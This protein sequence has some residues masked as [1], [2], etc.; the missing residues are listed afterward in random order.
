MK[1][2][3]SFRPNRLRGSGGGKKRSRVMKISKKLEKDIRSV[4]Q[5]VYC[6]SGRSELKYWIKVLRGL[7][8]SDQAQEIIKIA[9]DQVKKIDKRFEEYWSSQEG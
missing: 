4:V 1:F 7:T 9:K 6:D 5:A 8:E 3:N 2:P